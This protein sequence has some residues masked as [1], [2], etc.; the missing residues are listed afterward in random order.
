MTYVTAAT[1]AGV[2]VQPRPEASTY[3]LY[4]QPRPEAST[5]ILYDQLYE[6]VT[7]FM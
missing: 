1:G 3:I 2:Y 5:Y 4:V 7:E 6:E